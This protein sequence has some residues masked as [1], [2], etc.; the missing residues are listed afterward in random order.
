MLANVRC[1]RSGF[2]IVNALGS[3]ARRPVNKAVGRPVKSAPY[4]AL[5]SG[6]LKETRP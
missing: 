4:N 1:T 6:S 3:G 5:A 2:F